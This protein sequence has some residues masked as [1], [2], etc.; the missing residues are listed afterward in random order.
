MS[1]RLM[2]GAWDLHMQSGQKLVLLSLCDQASDA[3]HCFPSVATIARRCSMSGRAVQNHIKTL[4]AGGFLKRKERAGHSTYYKLNP[5]RI[6]TP[7]EFAPPQNLHPTPAES[8]PPPP[9]NLH[10]T[11]A[12]SA[13]PPP[14]N[15][16]PTPAE[17]AP[18]TTTEPPIEPKEKQIQGTLARPDGVGEQVWVDFL[19]IRKAKRSPLTATALRGIEREAAKAGISLGDALAMCCE[20]GWQA[21]KADWMQSDRTAA[22]KPAGRTFHDLSG[23]DYTKGVNDDLSF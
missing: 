4:E 23:M 22:R 13:P 14:Q 1:I 3:G 10:P 16:H 6:C 20:R 21:F 19:A 9:Q 18:I 12:E 7:A 5:R 11:P 2:N 15:L 17:S 8:A